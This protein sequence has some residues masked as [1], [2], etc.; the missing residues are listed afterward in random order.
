MTATAKAIVQA[1]YVPNVETTSYTTAVGMRT[2]IDKYTGYNGDTVARTLTVKI[3]PSGGSA[4]ASNVMVVKA[5]QPGESYT[6]PEIVG[7]TLNAG[8]FL[9]ELA[10][11]ASVITRRMSGREFT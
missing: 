7:H 9:S 8:D 4:G 11:A 3:V 5:L 10:S 1:G 2:T 6:F